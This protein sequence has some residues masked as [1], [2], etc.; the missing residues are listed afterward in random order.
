MRL[1][2]AGQIMAATA[3]LKRNPIRA[4]PISTG[5]DQYLRCGTYAEIRNGIRKASVLMAKAEERRNTMATD[6]D[7]REFLIATAAMR[8]DGVVALS[9]D[10]L[11]A[12]TA[13][14]GT[15]SMRARGC[16]RRRRRRGQSLDRHWPEDRV[17][18]R[19]N[20]SISDKASDL[21]SD[22]DLRRVGSATGP[23]VQSRLRRTHVIS[24]TQSL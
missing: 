15:P 20:Q 14:V 19:V 17:L 5:N 1:L 21:E 7:R 3:L 16:R 2:Q 8:V 12:E 13:I 10:A 23:K 9:S 4:M 6:I 24:R 18:I 11:A 22:D